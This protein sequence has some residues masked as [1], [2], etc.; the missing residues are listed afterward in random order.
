LKD[1]TDRQTTKESALDKSSDISKRVEQIIIQVEKP[2]QKKLD[3]SSISKLLENNGIKVDPSYGPF[4]VN[5]KLGRFV[6]RGFGT[7]EAQKRANKI[8]GFTVFSDRRMISPI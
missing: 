6:L 1:R 8:P 2:G 5:P 3:M 7:V 4:C